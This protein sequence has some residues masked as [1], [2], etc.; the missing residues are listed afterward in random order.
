MKSMQTVLS[1][2]ASLILIIMTIWIGAYLIILLALILAPSLRPLIADEM[3]PAALKRI[4]SLWIPVLGCFTGYWFT[5]RPANISAVEKVPVAHAMAAIGLT[6]GFLLIAIVLLLW[7]V[8]FVDYSVL[9]RAIENIQTMKTFKQYIDETIE[10][11]ALMS[12]LATTPVVWLT[13]NR[14]TRRPTRPP[15][16]GAAG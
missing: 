13:G 8:Y 6:M 5:Q 10:L 11:L 4:T 15:K 7:D 12:F 14:L 9:A 3:I 16:S 2:R 1:E